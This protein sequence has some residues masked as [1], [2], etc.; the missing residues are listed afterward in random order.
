MRP[1]ADCFCWSPSPSHRHRAPP[2]CSWTMTKSTAAR[3]QAPFDSQHLSKQKPPS[4]PQGCAVVQRAGRR[5]RDVL[6][7][8]LTRGNMQAYQPLPLPPT[9]RVWTAQLD[10]RLHVPYVLAA[11]QSAA[12]TSSSCCARVHTTV[13]IPRTAITVEQAAPYKAPTTLGRR[14]PCPSSFP[15]TCRRGR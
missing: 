8:R 6:D 15:K 4:A 1:A 5:I 13:V 12:S 14:P 2:E 11:R 10:M 3:A 9:R 7:S